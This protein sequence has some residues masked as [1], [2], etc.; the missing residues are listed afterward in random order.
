[1]IGRL[2]RDP[3]REDGITLIEMVVA[4]TLMAIFMTMFTGAMLQ[5]YGSIDRGDATSTVQ[6]QLHVAFLR[7]DRDIRYASAL[8]TP[9]T[10]SGTGYL[11]M[12]VEYLTV[13]T[14][15]KTCSQLRLH[16]PTGQPGTLQWRSWTY[17]N[18]PGPSWSI[19]ASGVSTSQPNA[20]VVF[21]LD[22]ESDFERLELN[23]TTRSG[24]G[25]TAA[26]VLTD[27][28]FTALNS[29]PVDDGSG[30]LAAPD[31]SGCQVGR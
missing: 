16:L 7:L 30:T 14:S 13:G 15:A 17:G 11:D 23:L 21:G 6:S 24:N 4:M 29:R 22:A 26:S 18:S 12:Y 5:V 19:L 2:V 20:F 3:G 9:G 10:D 31:G 25:T 28:K 8:T 1:V 27:I